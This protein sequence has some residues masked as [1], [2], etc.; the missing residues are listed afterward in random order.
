MSQ[1]Y[2]RPQWPAPPH[3]HALTTLRHLGESQSPFDTN[4]L[5]YAVGD[6]PVAVDANRAKLKTDLQLQHE[7]FWL[8]QTHSN[9]CVLFQKNT[10]ISADA[11]ISRNADQPL[12]IM[13]AD[14]LPILITNKEGS[15]VAAIHAGWR[16]LLAGIIENTLTKLYSPTDQ[17]LAWIGPGI[18]HNCFE[19]GGEVCEQFQKRYT[20]SP[21]CFLPYESK[22]KGNL[23][24]LAEKILKHL[25]VLAVYQANLC[26][27]E[28]KR[29][30][31]SYRRSGQT[32]RM[33]TLIWFSPS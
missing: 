15:E 27:F 18:C 28:Q 19:V 20:F 31:Y 25:G 9:E 30:F 33:A 8:N 2:L 32:G 21:E 17:L 14:C 6:D 22:W 5:S 10:L 29:L 13:T 3:V 26:T 1:T 12:V 11:A 16:G 4:N 7:P 24:C 23:P